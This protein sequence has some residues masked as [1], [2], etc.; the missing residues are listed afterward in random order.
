MHLNVDEGEVGDRL[1]I[2]ASLLLNGLIQATKDLATNTGS[3]MYDIWMNT[4]NGALKSESLAAGAIR[5]ASFNYSGSQVLTCALLAAVLS[6]NLK[7]FSLLTCIY[8]SNCDN[9][10]WID[11]FRDAGWHH[12]LC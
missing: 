12:H 8:H 7:A 10:Y 5:L 11:H 9:I 2:Q 1:N 6:T 4:S 3:S